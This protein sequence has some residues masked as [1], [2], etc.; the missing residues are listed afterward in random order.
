[1]VQRFSEENP[2]F[3]CSML[4]W[5][6]NLTGFMFQRKIHLMKGVKKSMTANPV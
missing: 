3:K 1:M 2:Y 5:T 4:N 6:I